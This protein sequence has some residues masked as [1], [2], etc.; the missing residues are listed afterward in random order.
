ML[1][2]LLP[3]F[4]S[5]LKTKLSHFPP[6][7]SILPNEQAVPAP[8]LPQALLLLL[9]LQGGLGLL[10]YYIQTDGG[11]DRSCGSNTHPHIDTYDRLLMV[12][13][14]S[15]SSPV[16]REDNIEGEDLLNT[17]LPFYPLICLSCR[18]T[19][20]P[21]GTVSGSYSWVDPTGLTRLWVYRADSQG[22]R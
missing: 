1:N 18:E 21:N 9:P 6:K 22:Y 10:P 16:E 8:P 15:S 5:T 13:V 17:I 19:V 14:G 12:L 2:A 3:T 7:T 4:K 20:L 11:R